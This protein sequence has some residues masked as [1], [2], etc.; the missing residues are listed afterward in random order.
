MDDA[1]RE[2]TVEYVTMNLFNGG[3]WLFPLLLAFSETACTS[4][5]EKARTMLNRGYQLIREEKG[6][7]AAKA[8]EEVLS[9]YPQTAEAT[10]ASKLLIERKAL[11]A[12]ANERVKKTQVLAAKTALEAFKLDCGRYP[13][14]QEGLAALTADPGVKGWSGPYLSNPLDKE[15]EYTANGNGEP[16]VSVRMVR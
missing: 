11:M 9:L 1:N 15:L 4:D 2:Q 14:Q 7:E 10:E 5:T 12:A 6:D 13:T 3:R 16:T 8:F